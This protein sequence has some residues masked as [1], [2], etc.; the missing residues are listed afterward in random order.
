MWNRNCLTKVRG[1]NINFYTF[2]SYCLNWM[3]GNMGFE[4][5]IGTLA[6]V[7]LVNVCD[8]TK[9]VIFVWMVNLTSE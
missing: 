5:L 9:Q 1:A 3:Y 2:G 7:D 4:L 8:F 6:I